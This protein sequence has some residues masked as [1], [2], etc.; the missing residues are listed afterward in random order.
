L[1]DVGIRRIIGSQQPALRHDVEVGEMT[2][3]TIPIVQARN[4]TRGRSNPIDVIVIHTM[5]SP[6]KPDTAESVAAWFAGP[7]APQASAHYCI[8]A[9]SI[10][11]CVRDMDVAWHAPGAN[12]NGLGLE[13]A[14]RA[15]QTA[16]D[17]SDEY[18]TKLLDLSA[19]LV[20]QKCTKYDIPATWLTAA[21]LRAGKR[22][23]TGHVQVSEAFKRTDHTDPG[24][25]FPVAAYIARVRAHLG[26]KFVQPEEHHWHTKAA[27]QT[28]MLQVGDEGYQVKRLQR[29]LVQRGFDA[30]AADGIFGKQ[31]AAAV[32]QAQVAHGLDDDG[33]A[34]PLTWAALLAG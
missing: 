13:H 9:D 30:G 20:A 16:A 7:N 17:W 28:P 27:A 31:T 6:E 14:G 25:S 5:E 24:K 19:E 21:Q 22:G 32:K 10:V 12:H 8:D 1:T 3:S 2:S 29:L 15:A 26:D 34:G 11:E 33:I 18:S 23:I 4:Y